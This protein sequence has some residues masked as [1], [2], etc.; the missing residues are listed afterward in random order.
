MA[1]PLND[2]R[3]GST[4]ILSP[5]STPV[6]FICLVT[7]HTPSLHHMPWPDQRLAFDLRHGCP[8]VIGL[9]T[10]SFPYCCCNCVR[11]DNAG[12]L[13][14]VLLLTNPTAPGEKQAPITKDTLEGLGVL[15]ED[16]IPKRPWSSHDLLCQTP[17]CSTLR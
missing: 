14:V 9:C 13:P 1:L 12:V 2:D 11:S 17:L 8:A 6:Y 4:T 10:H 16:A 15:G 5:L 3:R 7:L